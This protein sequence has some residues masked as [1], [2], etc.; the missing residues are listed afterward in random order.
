MNARCAQVLAA[1]AALLVVI[2][3]VPPSRAEVDEGAGERTPSRLSFIEGDVS[4]WRPG[5][6]DW[7]PAQIN[8]PLAP[9][10]ALHAAAGGSFEVQIGPR[11]FARADSDTQLRIASQEPGFLQLEV[12]AGRASFDLRS[13]KVGQTIEIATPN[14]AFTI[15]S[16]GYYR[17]DITGDTTAFAARRNGRATVRP[18]DGAPATVELGDV[19]IVQGAD[20]PSVRVDAAP[21]LDE[22]DGWNYGRSDQLTESVSARYVPEDVYGTEE[23]DRNGSW[24]DTPD[25][26]PVWVPTYVA[27][28]WAPYSDGRWLWDRHFG[29]SWI[30][31]APWGW[32]PCHYG[33]WVQTRGYWGWA[34]GPRVVAP[35]YAPALVAFFGGPHLG[36]SFGF[37]APTVGWVALGWGEPLVPWWGHRGFV[38]VPCWRGWGGPRVVNNIVIDRRTV[39]N[40]DHIHG[41]RNVHVK[42]AVIAVPEDRFA[43]GGAERFRVRGGNPRELVPLHGR[44]PVQPVSTSVD[45]AEIRGPRG[46]A[47]TPR[48]PRGDDRAPRFESGETRNRRGAGPDQ[49]RP[50]APSEVAA[51]RPPAAVHDLSDRARQPRPPRFRDPSPAQQPEIRSGQVPAPSVRQPRAWPQAAPGENMAPPAR[52]RQPRHVQEPQAAPRRPAPQAAAPQQA[53]APPDARVRMPR[54]ESPG[55]NLSSAPSYPVARSRPEERRPATMGDQRPST[56]GGQ[57]PLRAADPGDSPGRRAR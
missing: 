22:W 3:I 12:T 40:V 39:I 48:G 15:E 8:I 42:N 50:S 27:A 21:A 55:R 31:A 28:D 6:E 1:A 18:G 49:R 2:G 56:M 46:H 9:G 51:P 7:T 54:H 53:P 11:A 38:G 13:L 43:R 47:D 5:V 34:P 20:R 4:F 14:A 23:L 25:Y 16:S 44:L 29:W 19:V 37:G 57:R 24:R 41:Y 52:V 33:R 30:D 45:A 10:D 36:V 32:A 17:V 26:G 35:I